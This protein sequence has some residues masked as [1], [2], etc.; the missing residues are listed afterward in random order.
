MSQGSR[1]SESENMVMPPTFLNVSRCDNCPCL[2][3]SPIGTGILGEKLG[4]RGDSTV[5]VVLPAFWRPFVLVPLS[6][7]ENLGADIGR[8]P[9]WL[10]FDCCRDLAL[11]ES[12]SAPAVYVRFDVYALR[13]K[14][15]CTFWA[16]F[17]L[18][19]TSQYNVPL[20]VFFCLLLQWRRTSVCL[21]FCRLKVTS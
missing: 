18:R 5:F 13:A 1:W 3:P 15:W 9:C 20:S 6:L 7:P 12:G 2:N 21:Y 19:Q 16:P 8:C 4:L 14:F 10:Y 17:S 11:T